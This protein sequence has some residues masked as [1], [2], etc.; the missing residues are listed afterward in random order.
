MPRALLIAAFIG[1]FLTLTGCADMRWSKAG[2]DGALVS[3]DL[4]ECRAAALRRANPVISTPGQGDGRSDG[5]GSPGVMK[6]AAGSN[7]RFIA[8]HEETSR[9][10]RQRGYELRR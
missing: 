3:R 9:C 7:E 5:T 4:D 8:E 2:A 10:M 1:L 6:P